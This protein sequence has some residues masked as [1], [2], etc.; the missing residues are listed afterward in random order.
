[1]S[2]KIGIYLKLNK[3]KDSDILERLDSQENKQGYIKD[4]IRVDISLDGLR[5]L[6]GQQDCYNIEGQQKTD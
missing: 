5:S 4:L 2:N 6:Y 3:E 1:M